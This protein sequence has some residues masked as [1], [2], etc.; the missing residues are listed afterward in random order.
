[1]HSP[2]ATH[3]AFTGTSS[4]VFVNLCFDPCRIA[5]NCVNQTCF[6]ILSGMFVYLNFCHNAATFASGRGMFQCKPTI[7]L[8]PTFPAE[9]HQVL[10]T[11]L[12]KHVLV[13]WLIAARTLRFNYN[14]SLFACTT[15][16]TT[17]QVLC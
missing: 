11:A 1:M 17:D 5:K 10:G 7:F 16:I 15:M 4:R 2:F 6:I 14:W 12:H 13:T 8:P 3:C 9:V